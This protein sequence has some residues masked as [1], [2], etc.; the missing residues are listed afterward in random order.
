MFISKK[1]YKEII[2][3][4]KSY[5]EKD[6]KKQD[7][8]YDLEI[9][10]SKLENRI[11]ILEQNNRALLNNNNKLID[12]IEKIINELGCYEVSSNNDIRIPIY[13]NECT[14]YKDNHYLNGSIKKEV[15]IPQIS[16]MRVT[17]RNN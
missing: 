5:K 17:R 8:I 4:L 16:F 3:S 2:E 10:K 14:Y 9:E 6:H 13:K 15:I 11:D 1:K 7:K 12:W